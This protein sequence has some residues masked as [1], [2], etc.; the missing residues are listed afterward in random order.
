MV[1][2]DSRIAQMTNLLF[3]KK[4]CRLPFVNRVL[5]FGSRA[6][7]EANERADIDL[8]ID[9]PTAS[10]NDWLDLLNIIDDAELLL[11]IDI[12]RFDTVGDP[13]FKEEITHNHLVLFDRE[14][15]HDN[16]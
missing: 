2:M 8:A 7:G 4:L 16:I 14:A 1:E 12:I 5:L 6:K 3:F 11:P 13:L 10:E 15:H 9:C